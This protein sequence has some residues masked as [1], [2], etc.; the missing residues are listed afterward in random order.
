MCAVCGDTIQS[1]VVFWWRRDSDGLVFH[2]CG[3]CTEGKSG[4]HVTSDTVKIKEN[5]TYSTV[6]WKETNAHKNDKPSTEK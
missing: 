5:A 3:L 4:N 1:N 2:V 6:D